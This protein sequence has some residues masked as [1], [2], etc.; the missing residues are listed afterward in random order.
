MDEGR[1]ERCKSALS[2][3][4]ELTL[5]GGRNSGNV[6]SE[7]RGKGTKWWPHISSCHRRRIN[8]ICIL[9][10]SCGA[11]PALPYHPTPTNQPSS[12]A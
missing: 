6:V 10:R 5:D 3:S 8:L 9:S 11:L 2:S 4:I 7:C 1:V 12:H